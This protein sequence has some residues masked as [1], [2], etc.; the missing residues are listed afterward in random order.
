MNK[1]LFVI[2]IGHDIDPD[3]ARDLDL[4]GPVLINS[5]FTHQRSITFVPRDFSLETSDR[6]LVSPIVLLLFDQLLVQ[7]LYLTLHLPARKTR[8]T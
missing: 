1:S 2:Q 7:L 6:Q 8:S 4:L 5:C 3:L